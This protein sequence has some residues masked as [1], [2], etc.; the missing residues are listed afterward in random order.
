MEIQLVVACVLSRYRPRL[1]GTPPDKRAAVTLK[2][3]QRVHV[4]FRSIGQHTLGA[5]A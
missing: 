5:A 3:R 2:P 4:E 1:L